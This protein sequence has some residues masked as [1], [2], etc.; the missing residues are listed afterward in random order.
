MKKD[1]N[2]AVYFTSQEVSPVKID[3]ELKGYVWERVFGKDI[4]FSRGEPIFRNLY[5][6]ITKNLYVKH[7]GFLNV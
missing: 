7:I 5:L 4:E 6:I 3:G 1:S 2:S